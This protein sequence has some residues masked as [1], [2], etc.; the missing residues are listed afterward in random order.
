MLHPEEGRGFLLGTKVGFLGGGDALADVGGD[1]LAG[2]GGDVDRIGER[3]GGGT[4]GLGG[5]ELADDDEEC[6]SFLARF[7]SCLTE[8][9]LLG[10]VLVLVCNVDVAL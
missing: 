1:V 9:L 5:N 8:V 2:V 6:N 4:V 3:E 7:S 10:R